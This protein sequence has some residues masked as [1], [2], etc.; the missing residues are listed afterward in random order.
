VGED[1]TNGGDNVGTKFINAYEVLTYNGA[2]TESVYPYNVSS[3]NFFDWCTDKEAMCEAMTTRISNYDNT[4]ISSKIVSPTDSSLNKVKSI[5]NNGDVLVSS[6][7]LGFDSS[8][9]LNWN[10]KTTTN[11]EKAAYES[12]LS[13]SGHLMTIVGYDDNIQC[14]INGDGKIESG[15]KGA[16]KVANS[17]GDQWMNNGYI[18]VMYDAL[19][20]KS[21]V[22]TENSTNRISIFGYDT[23]N[24]FNYIEVSNYKVNLILDVN[25]A[26]SDRYKIVVGTEYF[27]EPDS[28]FDLTGYSEATSVKKSYSGDLLVDFSCFDDKKLSYINASNLGYLINNYSDDNLYIHSVSFIDNLANSTKIVNRKEVVKAAGKETRIPSIELDYK[29]GDVNYD[30]KLTSDDSELILKK[31]TLSVNF[32][33]LQNLLAD[34]N[35]DGVVDISDVVALNNSLSSSEKAKAIE[36]MEVLYDDLSENDKIVFDTEFGSIFNEIRS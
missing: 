22:L 18:W 28:I 34:Y 24:K 3:S 35:K 1:V 36:K 27:T 31:L 21:S 29:L 25:I 32:S 15:E 10:I 9:K 11:G 12:I 17:W 7:S 16:F 26:T 4:E 8:N 23:V 14:D 20:S 19:N 6:L 5:L 2:V 30:G 13:N 33:N